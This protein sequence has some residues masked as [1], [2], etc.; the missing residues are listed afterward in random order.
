ME[1]GGAGGGGGSISV[2]SVISMFGSY[3][4]L[5]YQNSRGI[6]RLPLRKH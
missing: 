4:Q 2:R 5:L 3:W 1:G 6:I